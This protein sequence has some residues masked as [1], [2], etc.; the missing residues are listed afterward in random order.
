MQKLHIADAEQGSRPATL[1]AGASEREQEARRARHL[2]VK[3]PGIEPRPPHDLVHVP[4]IGDRE[5]RR[6]ES[7]RQ[8]RVL[9]LGTRAL[10]T[11][12]QDLGVVEGQRLPAA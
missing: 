10:D 9:E 7:R 2:A 3:V 5:L 6:A 8:R 11:V 4:E 1:R 12:A